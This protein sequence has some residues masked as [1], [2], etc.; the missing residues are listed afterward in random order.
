M[1]DSFDDTTATNEADTGTRTPPLSTAATVGLNASL[2]RRRL[3]SALARGSSNFAERTGRC[4]ERQPSA[5]NIAI[6]GTHIATLRSYVVV[7]CV[8][9]LFGVY[10]ETNTTTALVL[11]VELSGGIFSGISRHQCC[12]NA[13]GNASFRIGMHRRRA[14]LYDYRQRH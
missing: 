4:C 3:Q 9:M 12:R 10:Y 7:R 5:V 1:V 13:W 8:C 6:D 11:V 2:E 14:Q